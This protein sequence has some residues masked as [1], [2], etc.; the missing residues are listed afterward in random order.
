MEVMAAADNS[1]LLLA[2]IVVPLI[3]L[4][5]GPA[6]CL[7]AQ[8]VHFSYSTTSIAA[9]NSGL[10]VGVWGCRLLYWSA[11]DP[12]AQVRACTHLR[13]LASAT[14]TH[15]SSDAH[16]SCSPSASRASGRTSRGDIFRSVA[17]C[18]ARAAPMQPWRSCWFTCPY[19]Y[20]IMTRIWRL[21]MLFL[22]SAILLAHRLHQKM[23]RLP[24]PFSVM[25]VRK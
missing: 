6:P 18:S 24:K 8:A 9:S 7:Y 19:A 25:R 3:M 1:P 17:C 22:L 16:P 5:A 15:L 20:T 21:N 2:Y 14:H 13:V 4:A 12:E 11:N 10:A 23:L